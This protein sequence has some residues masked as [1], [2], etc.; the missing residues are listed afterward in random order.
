MPGHP[1]EVEDARQLALAWVGEHDGRM[2]IAWDD[3]GRRPGDGRHEI[4]V[5]LAETGERGRWRARI[6]ILSQR[7]RLPDALARRTRIG[8]RES[9][10]CRVPRSL[11][12]NQ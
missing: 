8:M 7:G 4:V 3:P 5:L 11:D 6:P 1:V 9:I 2:W 10:H 12:L